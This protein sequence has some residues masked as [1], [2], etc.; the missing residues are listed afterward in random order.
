MCVYLPLGLHKFYTLR[1][2]NVNP[3]PF[4]IEI[5]ATHLFLWVDIGI[6]KCVWWIYAGGK[7]YLHRV[8]IGLY[9]YL[10]SVACRLASV[11]CC[12]RRL[13]GFLWGGQPGYICASIYGFGGYWI[14]AAKI[15]KIASVACTD[16]NWQPNAAISVY[17]IIVIDIYL[18][19]ISISYKNYISEYIVYIIE[20]N[21]YYIPTIRY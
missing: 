6:F 4:G 20:Y 11:A 7:F 14:G 21:T 9:L 13:L 17:Y 5:N 2:Y 10:A 18:K 1:N 3:L 19:I 15:A 8:C 16:V 12:C